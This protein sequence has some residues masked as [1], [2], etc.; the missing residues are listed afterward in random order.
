MVDHPY[1]GHSRLSSLV[2]S[3]KCKVP[4]EFGGKIE[5]NISVRKTARP[6]RALAFP[7][8]RI[9]HAPTHEIS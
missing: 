4:I 6:W 2:V 7:K 8:D 3:E 9:D 1:I 5:G